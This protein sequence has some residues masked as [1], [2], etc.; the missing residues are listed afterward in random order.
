MNDRYV[1][2]VYRRAAV[3]AE[4][5]AAW[6]SACTAFSSETMVKLEGSGLGYLIVLG[7]QMIVAASRALSSLMED[8][9][10]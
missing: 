8:E 6:L 1:V 4:A 7:R 10:I 9:D 2:A 5:A 3:A